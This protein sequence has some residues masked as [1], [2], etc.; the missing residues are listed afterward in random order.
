MPSVKQVP[1]QTVQLEDSEIAAIINNLG[2]S[3]SVVGSP[4]GVVSQA[5]VAAASGSV[6]VSDLPQTVNFLVADGSYSMLPFQQTVIDAYNND[7]LTSMR[8]AAVRETILVAASVFNDSRYPRSSS[9]KVVGLNDPNYMEPNFV[10]YAP[11]P[12]EDAP[13]L[14]AADYDIQGFN[15]NTPL[16]DAIRSQRLSAVAYVETLQANYGK[17]VKAILTVLTDGEENASTRETVESCRQETRRLL[18]LGNYIPVYVAFGENRSDIYTS[19]EFALNVGYPWGNIMG[20][21]KQGEAYLVDQYEKIYSLNGDRTD[22]QRA[23]RRIFRTF[24]QQTVKA[25]QSVVANQ[26]YFT[27]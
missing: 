9:R 27:P 25:S 8:G 18:E 6:P 17:T 4:A 7:L 13:E 1:G 20:M 19:V 14:T 11:L 15:S 16:L 22:A 23:L 26:G 5:V 2:L 21:T 3:T 24:S 10:V 12:L